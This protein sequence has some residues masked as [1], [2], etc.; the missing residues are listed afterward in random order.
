L[1][2]KDQMFAGVRFVGAHYAWFG[3]GDDANA[4]R[5]S[6]ERKECK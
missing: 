4:L 3:E 2:T 1:E 6:D 5:T